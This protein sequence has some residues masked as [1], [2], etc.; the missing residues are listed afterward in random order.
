MRVVGTLAIIALTLGGCGGQP[1]AGNGTGTLANP[2][3]PAAGGAKAE[4]RRPSW[5]LRR[6]GE[7]AALTLLAPGGTATIQLFC[8]AAERR[9]LVNVPSFKPI[10]SEERLSFGSGGQAIVLVAD[11]RGDHERG[12]I[13]GS[14]AIPDELKELIWNPIHASYGAQHS[15]P[16][17]APPSEAAGPFLSV[18]GEI[19]T[20][21]RQNASFPK[22]G[23]SP[24]LVQDGR[25]LQAKPIKAVGTEPF[26]AARIEGR[27]VTYSHPDNPKGT[28]IWARINDGPDGGVWV[29]ALNG[30]PF[31]LRLR[32][33]MPCSD[34]M[35]D[36]QY[37]IAAWLTVNGEDRRGCAEIL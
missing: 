10:G 14:G 32:G 4:P 11:T 13:T 31:V 6:S 26:W 8:S 12:G 2:H 1:E 23:T 19:A 29:G 22:A 37:S 24:C 30:K 9:L 15:G 18:C 35:S 27:C 17:P 3:S 36:N 16:H 20:E 33:S 21:A 7:G 28:R 34:G 25:L 5:T